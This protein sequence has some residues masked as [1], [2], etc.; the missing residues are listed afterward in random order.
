M[1]SISSYSE[2]RSEA[3]ASG[4]LAS[5]GLLNAAEVQVLSAKLAALSN[6]IRLMMLN[7]IH[8]SGGE[9]CVC[10]FEEVFSLSQSTISHHM[11]LLRESG[12]VRK[13][14]RGH[15]IHYYIVPEAFVWVGRLIN[16]FTRL[17]GE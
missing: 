5:A 7:M 14:R 10:K 6:P 11:K 17:P 9:L 15:W 13:V 4:P 16:D 1:A 3:C 2:E 12:F 8:Q